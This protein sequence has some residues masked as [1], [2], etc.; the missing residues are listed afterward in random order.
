MSGAF[1]LPHLLL[2][3]VVVLVLFG[4][5]KVSSMMSE[6]GKGITPR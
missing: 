3:G 4:K 1:S 6:T 5:G 2:I